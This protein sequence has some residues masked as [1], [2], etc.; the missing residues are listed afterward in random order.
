MELGWLQPAVL[1][2]KDSPACPVCPRMTDSGFREG[3][4]K[5]NQTS[6]GREVS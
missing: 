4:S 1:E 2:L 3:L 5:V 6:S